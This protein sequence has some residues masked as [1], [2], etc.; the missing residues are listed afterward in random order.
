M[1]NQSLLFCFI[2]F[3]FVSCDSSGN[4][5]VKK[6]ESDISDAPTKIENSEKKEIEKVLESDIFTTENEASNEK[7]PEDLQS[8][9]LQIRSEFTRIESLLNQ[10]KLTPKIKEI[11][12]SD[13]PVGGNLTFFYDGNTIVKVDHNFHMGDHFGQESSYYF[14][15]G[16][17]IF[18][19]HRSGTWSF[20][21]EEDDKGDS[22]TKDDMKVQRDYFN[23]GKIVKQLF[24][25]YTNFSNK[26]GKIES[27]VPNKSIGEGVEFTLAGKVIFDLAEKDKIGCELFTN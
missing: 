26:K 24:K 15:D 19:F 18:G 21:G 6:N 8:I 11:N 7:K 1:K 27:E 22:I 20:T 23:D 2:L 13:E 4:E 12:C 16:K 10:G 14:K 9:T 3:V 17:L 5:R 25:D